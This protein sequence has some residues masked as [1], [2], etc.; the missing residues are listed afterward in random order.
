MAIPL[1]WIQEM[2]TDVLFLYGDKMKENVYAE[3]ILATS[4]YTTWQPASAL[5]WFFFCSQPYMRQLKL[6]FKQ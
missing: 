1:L 2:N 6:I 4:L 3:V 5:V